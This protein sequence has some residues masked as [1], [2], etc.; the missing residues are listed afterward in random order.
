MKM[1]GD[2]NEGGRAPGAA[3]ALALAAL[4]A[5]SNP[6]RSPAGSPRDDATPPAGTTEWTGARG[7]DRQGA[8]RETDLVSS[9]SPAGES[10]VWRAD[11][12]GSS[13][14]VVFD[15]RACVSGR[16]G[17]GATLQEA[18]ACF[19]AAG[20]SRLW[21]DRLPVPGALVLLEHLGRA[22]LA[23]DP[24]TGYVFARGAGG[25]L[26]AYDREGRRV[27]S[28]SLTEELGALPGAGG[29]IQAPLVDG[30][31]LLLSF[32]SASW[33]KHAEPRHRLHA[34]DKRTG[35][36][37]WISTPGDPP[38]D[39]NVQS[40]LVVA[41]TG[42]QRLLIAGNADGSVYA[43]KVA[44][45]ETVW[46]FRLGRRGLDGSVL[47][48]GDRV[49]VAHGV[50]N[51]DGA[52]KGRVVCIDATG[53]GDVTA[54]HEL[55]RIDELAAG[56]SCPAYH[57][58]TLYVV[59]DAAR[60]HAISAADG[61][62]RWT[63]DLGAAGG[64]SPVWADGKLYVAQS[65]GRFHVLRPAEDGVAAL[66]SDEIEAG[67][68]RA[69]M[70]GSPAIAY[71]RVYLATSAGLYCLGDERRKLAP[72]AGG[73][74]ALVEAAGEGEAAWLQ[75]VPAEVLVAT[76]GALQFRARTYDARGRLLGVREPEWKVVGLSGLLDPK[77]ELKLFPKAPP[78]AGTVEARLG[79]LTAELR[80]RRVPAPPW[81]EEFE[82]LAAGV[83]PAYWV[84]AAGDFAVQEK[85][86][87]RV[88][89]QLRAP[90]DGTPRVV[91]M[92]LPTMTGYTIAA[93]VLDGRA[94]EG[95]SDVGLVN[96]GYAF[97]L[98]GDG[99]RARIGCGP[100]ERIAREAD[101]PW[102]RG[103]W[104]RVKLRVEVGG[105]KA[106]IR[107]KA[108]NRSH[109]EPESWTLDVEDPLAIPGG[110]PALL[111]SSRAGIYYDN[112]EVTVNEPSK[113]QP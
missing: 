33:G 45:G 61:R 27:W 58:G 92:G 54:T 91:Y 73:V 72:A 9:W 67:G 23:G 80:V 11:F 39:R 38:A 75:I 65:Q 6:D 55:W 15:G 76:G 53:H 21:E 112:I 56:R 47:A 63:H 19:D 102:E 41:E 62:V 7:P 37:L 17:E 5:C 3:I 36:V 97:E 110:S 69:E 77:G 113:A 48:D 105:A 12:S 87:G 82:S 86:G 57:D 88:L 13:T 35:E 107:G 29:A 26:I 83:L 52:T 79:E 85:E 44:T 94:P 64:G 14:P 104:Y 32:V 50:E 84:G 103:V 66:D 111:G 30:D 78:A 40:G 95:R 100:A 60:L 46:S 81:R 70:H 1:D 24:E 71:G 49:W 93:D 101:F 106:T 98:L 34:F 108:W 25:L 28:V 68:E 18:V 16:S 89:A 43:I 96:G 99:R 2:G 20:G 59:D 42:G 10:V 4:A 51:R 74:A 8:S 22:N 31:R 90:A 109:A